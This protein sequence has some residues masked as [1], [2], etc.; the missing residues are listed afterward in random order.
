MLMVKR[1]GQLFFAPAK[2]LNSAAQ[3]LAHSEA[4]ES[5]MVCILAFITIASILPRVWPI[6]NIWEFLLVGIVI[7]TSICIAAEIATFIV[8]LITGILLFLTDWMAKAYDKCK[9]DKE[10]YDSV[11]SIRNNQ[12]ADVTLQYFI[13]R[14]AKLDLCYAKYLGERAP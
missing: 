3:K 1:I 12:K 13:A 2:A 8:S 4:F 10:I 11:K 5:L 6:H 9:A 7:L 14:E